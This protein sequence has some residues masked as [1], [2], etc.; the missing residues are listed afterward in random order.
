VA[1]PGNG[2]NRA[3]LKLALRVTQGV[4]EADS[5]GLERGFLGNPLMQKRLVDLRRRQAFERGE[6]VFRKETFREGAGIVAWSKKLD[7]DKWRLAGGV[8]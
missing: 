6:I 7:V 8:S 5:S 2:V 1:G 4:A 3:V